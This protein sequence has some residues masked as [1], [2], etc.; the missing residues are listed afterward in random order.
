MIPT[1]TRPL[2]GICGL[3]INILVTGLVYS[4]IKKPVTEEEIIETSLEDE[5]EISLDDFE[6]L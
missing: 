4:L 1:M 3:L 2:A 5:E 6:I